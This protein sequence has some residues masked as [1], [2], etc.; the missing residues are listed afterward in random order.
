MKKLIA[1]A[2]IGFMSL[3]AFGQQ[4]QDCETARQKY[5]EAN[6]DVKS[7]KVDPWEHYL[8]AG[9]F[10][11]RKWYPCTEEVKVVEAPKLPE[12]VFQ[13]D[14][15]II[16]DKVAKTLVM[17]FKVAK[18]FN[19]TDIESIKSYVVHYYS[20]EGYNGWTPQVSHKGDIWTFTF[21]K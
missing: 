4:A 21:N 12:S 2:V 10:E 16:K 13:T 6:P 3:T 1:I 19:N 5:L 11:G 17:T 14:M 20:S 15:T 8:K 18:T 7:A 9:K